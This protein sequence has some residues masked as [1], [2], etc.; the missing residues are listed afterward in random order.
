LLIFGTAV[1]GLAYGAI[2]S[3]YP[4]ITADF[5]GIKNMGVNYG[6]IFTGWGLAGIIGPIIGGRVADLTGTYNGSYIV[7]GLMLV[8]GL[9][10]VKSIKSPRRE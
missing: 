10:L 2:F 5:F 4:A 9:L 8:V 3:L 1:A 7:A 6:I